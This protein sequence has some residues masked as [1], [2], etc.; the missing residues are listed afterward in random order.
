MGMPRP[1]S[2]Q[3]FKKL[4][5]AAQNA[6]ES[7]LVSQVDQAVRDK[8]RCVFDDLECIRNAEA[9]GQEAVL[10]DDSGQV[11]LDQEGQPVSDP[12]S[13]WTWRG[14]T[15]VHAAGGGRVSNYDFQPGDSVW[16]STIHRG[17]CR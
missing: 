12:T 8:V 5:K 14:K 10:T 11:L 7:E 16:S 9:Q 13:A 3:I 15:G 4:K 2:A 6:A 1:A 17:Q